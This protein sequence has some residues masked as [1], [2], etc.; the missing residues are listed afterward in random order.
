MKY[1]TTRVSGRRHSRGRLCY[2]KII[3]GVICPFK[4]A[5]NNL[6]PATIFFRTKPTDQ[7][8]PKSFSFRRRVFRPIPNRRAVWDL[9]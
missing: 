3:T 1:F 9:F 6:Q 7:T 8:T 2:I 5:T 4:P